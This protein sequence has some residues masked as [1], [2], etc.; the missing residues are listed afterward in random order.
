MLSLLI[1]FLFVKHDFSYFSSVQSHK[2]CSKVTFSFFEEEVGALFWLLKARDYRIYVNFCFKCRP[3]F[4]IVNFLIY[5]ICI[6]K[7]CRFYGVFLW[8]SWCS[9]PLCRKSIGDLLFRTS[10]VFFEDIQFWRSCHRKSSKNVGKYNNPGPR[11]L[12][13]KVSRQ[14]SRRQSNFFCKL[15]CVFY[16]R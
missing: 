7:R 11:I 5:S 6:L 10:L 9:W 1:L 3:F 13:R 16:R 8:P 12:F 2:K 15:A 4:Y 14:K